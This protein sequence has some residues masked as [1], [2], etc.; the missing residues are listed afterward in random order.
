MGTIGTTQATVTCTYL[1]WQ[2]KKQAEEEWQWWKWQILNTAIM[3]NHFKQMLPFVWCNSN[4]Q[5]GGVHARGWTLPLSHGTNIPLALPQCLEHLEQAC[6]CT[7]SQFWSNVWENEHESEPNGKQLQSK[8]NIQF[9]SCS[10]LACQATHTSSRG[11]TTIFNMD[12]KEVNLAFQHV[13]AAC[14]CSVHLSP[15]ATVKGKHTSSGRLML[16]VFFERLCWMP[17]SPSSKNTN[18]A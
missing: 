6:L 5:Q 11:T 18:P 17:C 13:T 9:I 3:N 8:M 1:H 15:C 2:I 4:A 16:V 12:V 14:S 10:K 7:K